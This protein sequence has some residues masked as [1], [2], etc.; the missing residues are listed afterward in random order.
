MSSPVLD[1]NTCHL[2]PFLPMSSI[3]HMDLLRLKDR[4]NS[5]VAWCSATFPENVE[6]LEWLKLERD[7]AAT[8]ADFVFAAKTQQQIQ[9]AVCARRRGDRGA[10]LAHWQVQL[11]STSENPRMSRAPSASWGC[12]DME[13]GGCLVLGSCG[14]GRS[15]TPPAEDTKW[16]E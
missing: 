2:C 15:A 4:W 6:L 10:E 12:G 14:G 1:V 9:D 7:I 13:R 8:F 3:S 11:C 5:A 16:R